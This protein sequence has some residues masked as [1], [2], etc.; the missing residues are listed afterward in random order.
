MNAGRRQFMAMMVGG[1]AG[2][3]A[4]GCTPGRGTGEA[5]RDSS[6]LFMGGGRFVD[7]E[8][9]LAVRHVMATSRMDGAEPFLYPVGFFPHGIVIDPANPDRLVLFEK[10]GPGACEIDLAAGRMSRTLAPQPGCHFYGHGAFSSDGA[11]LYATETHLDSQ[12]GAITVRDARDLTL[13]GEFP[14]FGTNP[15][16]CRLFDGGRQLAITN[17]G[18]TIGGDLPAVAYVDIGSGRLGERIELGHERINAGHLQG[19]R[20]RDRGQHHCG[21]GREQRDLHRHRFR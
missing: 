19:I 10:K 14:T 9:D 2:L 15:H 12:Q 20:R 13:L 16:D 8:G 1:A 5:S 4:W 3:G 6:S 11:L 17:A 21:A 7:P 18:G